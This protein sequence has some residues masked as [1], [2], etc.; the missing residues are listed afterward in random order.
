MFFWCFFFH[1]SSADRRSV[2]VFISAVPI[3]NLFE[4]G[5]GNSGGHVLRE[6]TTRGLCGLVYQVDISV[7]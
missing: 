4:W 5:Q 2:C 1:F 6:T 7:M 3:I